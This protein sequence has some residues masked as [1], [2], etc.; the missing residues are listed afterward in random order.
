MAALLG[1][2]PALLGDMPAL[3]HLIITLRI[4]EI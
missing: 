1:D 4:R 3:S 2:M